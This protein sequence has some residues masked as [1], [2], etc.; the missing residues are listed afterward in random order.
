MIK[1]IFEDGYWWIEIPDELWELATFI[2]YSFGYQVT[3]P[4]R[5]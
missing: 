3:Y 1:S 5:H 4:T 2:E